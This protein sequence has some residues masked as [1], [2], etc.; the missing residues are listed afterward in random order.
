MKR[1][2]HRKQIINFLMLL[3]CTS[4]LTGTSF[5]KETEIVNISGDE[6]EI[7]Y[8][9]TTLADGRILMVGD[10]G[11]FGPDDSS[12][13]L[14][15]LN[16][17]RTVSWE[18]AESTADG[19]KFTLAAELEDGTIGTVFWR[20][21]GDGTEGWILRFFTPDG[22]PAGKDITVSA[23]ADISIGFATASRVLVRKEYPDG[24]P[25]FCLMDW[26]GNVIK[27]IG[28]SDR[29]MNFG[30]MTEETDG[31]V[32]VEFRQQDNDVRL[33]ILK[34]DLR[35]EPLW[36]TEMLPLWPDLPAG[37]T[38][39]TVPDFRHFTKTE[40][41]GYLGIQWEMFETQ[42][43][44]YESKY[45]L[46]KLDSEGRILWTNRE[47]F[48]NISGMCMAFAAADGKYAAWFRRE[49]FGTDGIRMSNP[50]TV[51]WFDENGTNLGTVELS[52]DPGDIDRLGQYAGM[53]M[54]IPMAY[55]NRLIPMQDG[56]WM[57]ALI[58]AEGANENY[59]IQHD[60]FAALIR[61]PEP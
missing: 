6:D 35:G 37:M 26:N 18:Y 50:R 60:S 5:A 14:L 52:M 10:K 58:S 22:K 7:L 25:V 15:C 45:A 42:D 40:D 54:V 23:D 2:I 59:R 57:S 51:V 38:V 24:V 47:T 36:E 11:E 21:T 49:H 16:G 48:E 56:L 19:G 29:Y 44:K 9:G 20:R 28:N 32:F 30:S 13:K 27:E 43:G 1:N 55:E 46:V 34:T 17:D 4:L 31:L 33:F 39:A 3:L 8:Y 61:I 53:Q 41:G 12:A